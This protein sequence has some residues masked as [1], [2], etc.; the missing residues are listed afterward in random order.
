MPCNRTW[1]LDLTGKADLS[2]RLR[3]IL[4]LVDHGSRACGAFR[5]FGLPACIRVD[6]EACFNSRLMKG[7]LAML[8]IAL[9]TTQ[10]HCPWQNGRI[11][12]FFGTLK[13]HLDRIAVADRDDLHCK[14]V[15]FRAWYNHARPHQH[16]GGH[17]PAEVWDGRT[18]STRCPRFVSFWDGAITGWWFPP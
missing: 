3:M 8:G 15:E 4:G 9:Q 18:K 13:R 10:P 17:T 1:A 6:N 14:L 5:T 16:L 12:R 2:G 7:A 11:E